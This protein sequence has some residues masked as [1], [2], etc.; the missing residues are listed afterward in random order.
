MNKI[1]KT[2]EFQTLMQGAEFYNKVLDNARQKMLHT[3]T[4]VSNVLKDIRVAIFDGE[5]FVGSTVTWAF[6]LNDK[7][8]SGKADI[9]DVFGAERPIDKIKEKIRECIEEEILKDLRTL[10]STTKIGFTPLQE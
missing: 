2:K 9:D 10:L 8:F 6:K 1:D 5:T 7:E 4:L 3:E